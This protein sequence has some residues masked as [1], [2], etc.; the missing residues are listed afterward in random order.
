MNEDQFHDMFS[1]EVKSRSK[2]DWDEKVATQ[3]M[4]ES[5]KIEV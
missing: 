1:S 3:V 5:V 4:R 2:K